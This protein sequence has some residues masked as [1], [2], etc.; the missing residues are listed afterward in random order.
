[1]VVRLFD[2]TNVEQLFELATI[3]NAQGVIIF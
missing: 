2:P 1:M 3:I